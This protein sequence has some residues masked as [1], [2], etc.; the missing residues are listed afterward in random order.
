MTTKRFLKKT[1]KIIG[2]IF[3][4]IVVLIIAVWIFINTDYGKRIVRNKIQS[5]LE[6]KLKTKVVIGEI[7]YSLPKW[8]EIKNLYIEDQKKDTLLFGEKLSVDVD[9]LKLINGNT[10]IRKVA[11]KNIYANISRGETDSFFN[12]QFILDAFSGNKSDTKVNKDT[13]AMKLTLKQLVLDNV[14]LK[15]SDKNAGSD[16]TAYIKNLDTKLTKF[17]PDRLQF[18]IE[19]FNVDGLDF[20]MTTY[21]NVPVNTGPADTA[22]ATTNDLLLTAGLLDLKNVNVVINDKT[23]GMYYKNNLRHFSLSDANFDLAKEKANAAAVLLDSSLIKFISP[24]P[25]VV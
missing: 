16:M 13:A 25:S 21:K 24:K 8:V 2:Y 17:Q 1:G 23:D 9:M 7:D 19:K 4:G 14:R 5:Y 3:L 20:S 11:L 6:N 12:Y 15:Y 22:T 18:G 10:F